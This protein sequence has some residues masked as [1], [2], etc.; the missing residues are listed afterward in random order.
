MDLKYIVR[1]GAMRFLGVFEPGP[2][3]PYG[4]GTDVVIRTD[5]G[6]EMGELLGEAHPRAVELLSEPTHGQVVRPMT[7]ADREETE[8]LKAVEEKEFQTCTQFIH[9]RKLQMELVD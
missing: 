7:Q 5:R 8:R 6:L 9:Q 1:H 2:A 4:R 3:G